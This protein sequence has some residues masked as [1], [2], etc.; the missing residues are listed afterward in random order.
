MKRLIP[1]AL[2]AL[3]FSLGCGSENSDS[4]LIASTVDISG[5]NIVWQGYANKDADL[6]ERF[7]SCMACLKT[8]N[9]PSSYR[10]KINPP[11]PYVIVVDGNFRCGIMADTAG[12]MDIY[13][14]IY[15]TS[16]IFHVGTIVGSDPFRHEIIHWG[17]G[18]GVA[19]HD[20]IY[21]TKCAIGNVN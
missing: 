6:L 12:C 7:N 2:L 17:T 19:Y 11:Y 13:H 3:F 10:V 1:S 14:T 8:L 5:V 20:S 9:P 15:I 18:L 16:D 21:F 4:N